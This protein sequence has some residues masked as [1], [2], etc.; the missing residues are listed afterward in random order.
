MSSAPKSSNDQ[1]K[2]SMSETTDIEL[3]NEELGG[4]SAAGNSA[5]KHMGD[6]IFE[7]MEALSGSAA[8]KEQHINELLSK[9]GDAPMST[10][11]AM[12]L[13]YEL[14]QL[15]LQTEMTTKVADKSSQG[16]QTLFK[17]Q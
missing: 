10:Q 3:S 9:N 11:D 1:S 2:E 16:V 7:Q 12:R 14:M 4:I 5:P 17:N 13:Q 8:E 6:N 15:N